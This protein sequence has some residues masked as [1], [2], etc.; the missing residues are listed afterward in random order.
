MSDLVWTGWV[1]VGGE[2]AEWVRVSVSEEYERA[3]KTVLA[4]QVSGPVVERLV[5]R[6]DRHP[7]D[8]VRPR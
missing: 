2:K 7:E 6:G 8:R 4:F 1:R 5:S 3:W